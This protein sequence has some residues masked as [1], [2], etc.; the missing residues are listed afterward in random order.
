MALEKLRTDYTDAT[1]EGLRKY[2][3]IKNEDK[4]V[5]FDDVTS[6]INKEKA[7]YTAKEVNDGNRKINSVIDALEE[8]DTELPVLYEAI[9]GVKANQG[10]LDALKTEK[11]ENLVSSIN[12]IKESM[13]SSINEISSKLKD[14][15]KAENDYVVPEQEMIFTDKTCT[16]ND[17]KVLSTSL[18]DVYFTSDTIEEATESGISVETHTGKIVLTA[19]KQPVSTIKAAMKVRIM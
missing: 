10:E 15:I 16:I 12:E 9:E 1:F 7:Y 4:T 11:K 19:Q 8:I 5:S 13:D 18:V 6:Y 2:N 3:E 14:F 17:E